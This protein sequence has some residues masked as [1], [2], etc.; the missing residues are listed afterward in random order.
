M[1]KTLQMLDMV[2]VLLSLWNRGQNSQQ[3]FGTSAPLVPFLK[4]LDSIECCASEDGDR[5]ID[6]T[7]ENSIS[8]GELVD[9]NQSFL[10]YLDYPDDDTCMVDLQQ[11]GPLISSIHKHYS[12]NFKDDL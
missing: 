7:F 4:R 9:A 1:A 2:K 5:A 11:V 6:D 8:D 12:L 10:D 3:G